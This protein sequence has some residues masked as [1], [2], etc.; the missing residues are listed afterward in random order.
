VSEVRLHEAMQD[1]VILVGSDAHVWPG[2]FTPAMRTF[3]H[4]AQ[5]LLPVAVVLNGDV[6]DGAKISRF[7]SIGH[8]EK[9]EV[10]EELAACQAFCAT[11]ELSLAEDT[12]KVWTLG[13]HDLRFETKLANEVSQYKGISGFHLKDHFPNWEPCWSFW[14]ND[15]VCI[16][17]RKSGGVHAAY[18]NT[19]RA[20]VTMVTGHTHMLNV[21]P[22]TDY[23]GTR[24]GV[25]TGFL[26]EPDGPQF[27]HYTEDD[28]CNW[29]SGM[30]VL[31]WHEGTLLPPELVYV[32]NKHQTYQF[33]GKVREI[34]NV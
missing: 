1:G 22:Y 14:V 23:R 12:R 13:N 27:V 20:G 16:K 29:N 34:P 4:L 31:S 21:T 2:P 30:V 3:V 25:Q 17:H 33:R 5:T 9:P 6:F 11:V 19:L 28:C 15:D 8:E 24:Y 26:A 18:N 32:N 7:P 10:A